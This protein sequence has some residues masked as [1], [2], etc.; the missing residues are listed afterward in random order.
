MSKGTLRQ[1]YMK[2][3]YEKE[4]E[5]SKEEEEND[6]RLHGR[7]FKIGGGGRE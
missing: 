3:T 1:T 7:R 5:R 2:T 4:E 6:S